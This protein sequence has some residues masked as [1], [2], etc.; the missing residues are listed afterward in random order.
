M[1]NFELRMFTG[2]NV[3]IAD[4]IEMKANGLKLF[5]SSRK[6]SLF[7]VS[8]ADSPLNCEEFP[9]ATVRMMV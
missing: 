7:S 9:V 6:N 3:V 5:V 1:L 4:S 2:N 8:F